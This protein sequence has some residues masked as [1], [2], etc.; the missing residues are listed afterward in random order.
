M[1]NYRIDKYLM[2]LRFMFNQLL[3]FLKAQEYKRDN[4]D[5]YST[6]VFNLF[7]N[8]L[9]AQ[10]ASGVTLQ[11]CDI[12]IQELNKV[13]AD[14]SLETLADLLNPF[15]KALAVIQNKEV[16]E[17]IIEKIFHPILEN[18]KT[19]PAP[20]SSDEEELAKQEHYHRTVDGGKMHPRTVK[21]VKE[22]INQKY[23]F[24]GFNILIYAQNYI[25]KQASATDTHESNRD[26]IYKLYD[27]AINLEPKPEREELTFTQ[28]QLV[29]RARTFVTMKMRKRQNV[30][31]QKAE[32]KSILKMKQMLSERIKDQQ[33]DIIKAIQEGLAKRD[34]K[35]KSPSKMAVKEEAKVI[36]SKLGKPTKESGEKKKEKVKADEVKE[37][38]I[39]S[40]KET[41]KGEKIKSDK[42]KPIVEQPKQDVKPK[43]PSKHS[44]PASTEKPGTPTKTQPSPSQSKESSPQK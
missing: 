37:V 17:R 30:R 38:V 24:S 44:T 8:Q 22:M 35:P 39:E 3:Q 16:K 5:W 29:N 21:E 26:E 31:E 13:D 15:L 6:A 11:I 18:N 41:P 20:S 33:E 4:L 1:D 2:F 25:L 28:Q 40:A 32:S 23:V 36:D 42:K 10:A 9:Q 27:F 43:S 19:M 12:F 34:E 14:A 7:K